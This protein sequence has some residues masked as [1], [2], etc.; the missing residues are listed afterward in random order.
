MIKNKNGRLAKNIQGVT[1]E[2]S[3]VF[4]Q[5]D[6]DCSTLFVVISREK[7][8]REHAPARI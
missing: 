8:P 5:F 3:I 1:G 4:K 2:R 6:D 7:W